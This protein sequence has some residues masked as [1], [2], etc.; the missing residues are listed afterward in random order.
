MAGKTPWEARIG[1]LLEPR[2]HPE[3]VY[4]YKPYDSPMYGGQPRI[5]WHACD[6]L[7]RYWMIEVKSIPNSRR[8]I[9]LLS[10]VTPGQRQALSG[11]AKSD[12]GVPILAVGQNR[13]LY[14]FDWRAIAWRAEPAS[15]LH[16]APNP[17]LLMTETMLQ[18]EWSPKYWKGFNLSQQWVML[19]MSRALATTPVVPTF[20]PPAVWGGPVIPMTATLSGSLS[21]AIPAPPSPSTSKPK[22][23]IRMRRRKLLSGPLLSKP[24]E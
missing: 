2:L 11:V 3:F 22:D 24:P 8:S 19:K 14:L 9:N 4:S 18:L 15:A 16:P 7:G 1:L 23:S 17:L 5:D 13:T 10:D 6:Q 20:P 21:P 12:V